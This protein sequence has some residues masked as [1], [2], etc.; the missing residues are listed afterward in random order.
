MPIK[1]VTFDLDDTLWDSGLVIRAAEVE[2]RAWI[3]INAP[4]M[5]DTFDSARQREIRERVMAEDP[6]IIHNLSELRRRVIE[7]AM[8]ACGYSN[9]ESLGLSHHAFSVFFEARQ[10]V[11]LFEGTLPML[12]SLQRNFVLGAL[13]NGNADLERVGLDRFFSFHFSA[14]SIGVG[15]PAPDMFNAA[16]AWAKALPAESV[17]VGDHPEHDML[18]AARLG[19]HTIWFNTRN[20]DA[21]DEVTPSRIAGSLHDIPQLVESIGGSTLE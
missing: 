13:S 9:E 18:G 20:F 16:M 6:K 17:H 11:V 8:L 21:L 1:L 4:L 12:E 15:K 5:A 7:G 14:E 2:M 19:I 3:A 10:K